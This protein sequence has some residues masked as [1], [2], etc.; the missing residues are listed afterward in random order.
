MSKKA[1]DHRVRTRRDNRYLDGRAKSE[2]FDA[3][4]FGWNKAR[5]RHVRKWLRQM[6]QLLFW[7][8]MT[9]LNWLHFGMEQPLVKGKK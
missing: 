1:R 6:P 3:H 4:D 9:Y 7:D 2:D 8:E 5:I